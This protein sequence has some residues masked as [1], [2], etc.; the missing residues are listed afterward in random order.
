MIGRSIVSM[1]P[2]ERLPG[3][4]SGV[5]K[6][7]EDFLVSSVNSENHFPGCLRRNLRS[8]WLRSGL[9]AHQIASATL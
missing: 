7:M 8:E 4:F 1:V 2:G 9:A 6:K 5:M 3:L